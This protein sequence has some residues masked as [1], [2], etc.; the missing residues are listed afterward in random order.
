M[1]GSGTL[2]VSTAGQSAAALA[3][4]SDVDSFG[5][6]KRVVDLDP[7]VS[8]RTF[9]LRVSEEKLDRRKLPVRR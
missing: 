7:K 5:D 9:D 1:S 8:H 2:S 4:I 6:L 3:G